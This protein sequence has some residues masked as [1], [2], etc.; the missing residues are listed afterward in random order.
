M[1]MRWYKLLL[2]GLLV[3]LAACG[4]SPAAEPEAASESTTES[5]AEADTEPT[6]TEQMG[7]S[8]VLAAPRDMAPG[9]TDPYYA[10]PMLHIWESLVATDNDWVPQPFLA[11][12]WEQSEDGLSWTFT[13]REDVVFSDGSPFNADVVIANVERNLQISPS[14]SPFYSLEATA[15]YGD[16]DR[17]EKVDDYTVRFVHNTV[18]PALPARLA[19][20]YSAMF[21][22]ASFDENGQFIDKPIGSG[23]FQ[24]VELVP[25]QYVQLEAN[26]NYWGEPPGVQTVRV[27]TIPDPE[28]RAAAL[29]AGEIQG[30]MDLGAIQPITAQELVATGEFAES[31]AIIPITHYIFVNGAKEPWND[32]R[33]RQAVSMAVDRAFMA[34]TIF[35]GYGEPA[36]SMLSAVATQWHDESITNPYDLEEAQALAA[37][38][39]GN[40][41]QRALLLIPSYQLERYPYRALGEYVQ[42]Q[43]AQIGIDAEIQIVE[44]G[45]YNETTEAG[46]YDLALSIQ[47]LANSEPIFLFSRYLAC[48]G[49]MNQRRS[50][51]YCNEEM[52]RLLEEVQTEPDPARRTEL[53]DTIQAIAARDLPIIPLM[54]D[55]SVV[56]FDADLEGYE[57]ETTSWVTLDTVRTR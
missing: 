40:E 12:S 49:D 17:I 38:V 16:L 22:P 27:R 51:G 46:E 8:V 26:P 11:E 21:A 32:V 24:V 13:L 4:T 39:L 45:A 52:T 30:V 9:P 33:L 3:L 53:Y 25:D 42:A 1:Q 36:G 31:T 55:M 44:G 47:G 29:R 2:V 57:V 43:L 35:L 54:Y 20:F 41:R 34:E 7:A 19:N 5:A 50:V 18:E 23:P 56:V 37:E 6:T 28:T 48:D 14:P 10:H 15:A